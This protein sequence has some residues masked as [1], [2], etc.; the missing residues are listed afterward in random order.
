MGVK[1]DR[2]GVDGEQ[3]KPD[4]VR[5]GYRAPQ[6]VLIEIANGKIFIG[7]TSPAWFIWH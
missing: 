7:A 1:V 4:I 2:V 5:L 3:S 6:R